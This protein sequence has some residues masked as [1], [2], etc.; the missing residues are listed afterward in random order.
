MI[1]SLLEHAATNHPD[2][3]LVAPMLD[4]SIFRYNYRELELRARKAAAALSKL[5]VKYGEIVGTLAWNHH[6]NIHNCR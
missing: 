4:G 1:S 5:G 2:T 3:E 6:W